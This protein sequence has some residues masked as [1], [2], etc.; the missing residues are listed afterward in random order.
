M[1]TQK[2][3]SG[4]QP[5]DEVICVDI[6]GTNLR[7]A[8]VHRNGTLTDK[9]SVST[10]KSGSDGKIVSEEIIRLIRKIDRSEKSHLLPISISSA[11]PL[12]LTQGIIAHCPNIPLGQV[13]LVKPLEAAFKR[14]VSLFKDTHAAVL[15]EKFFGNGQDIANLVYVT[16]ST[17]IGGGAIINNRLLI[18]RNGNA[19]EIGRFIV[20]D[21]PYH[22]NTCASGQNLPRIFALFCKQR[23]L[24]YNLAHV[25]AKDIFESARK[26]EPAA[27]QFLEELGRIN[28]N[29]LSSL[30]VAYEPER[31]IFGGSVFLHN[32]EWILPAML[33]HVDTYLPIPDI[34]ATK[35]GDNV[36]L[37]GAA[38]GIFFHGQY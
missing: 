29:G 32:Q 35:L 36:S 23:G 9:Q 21:D 11:G 33:R 34:H 18:G 19:T 31:V 4:N 2:I 1:Q 26:Q 8:R 22:W 24:S 37:L 17:G 27:L 5:V 15:G 10:P 7:V 16:I 13:P 6:G 14:P 38:A 30:I 3:I 12:D 20:S 28:G 25:T